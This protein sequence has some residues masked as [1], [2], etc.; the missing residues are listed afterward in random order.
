MTEPSLLNSRAGRVTLIMSVFYVAYGVAL[1]FLSRWLEDARGLDGAQIGAVLSLAQ[2]ARIFTGPAIAFWADSVRDRRTPIRVLALG[3]V[4]AFAAFFYAA[5]DFPWL[6][7]LGF[8]ALT[9]SQAMIPFIEAVTLRACEN[10]R[11]SYGVARGIGSLAFVIANVLGGL[12]IAR[13]GA[14]AIAVWV[15]AAYASVAAAA[16]TRLPADPAPPSLHEG[17][18]L[19][20]RWESAKLLLR[21]RR[22]MIAIISCGILQ[23][24]HAFYYGFSTL[25]WRNEGI[26]SE[27]AGMLWGFAVAVE[28]ALL[29][30]LPF[31][32]RRFSPEAFVMIGGVGAIVRWII[33]GFAPSGILLWLIQGMHALSFAAVHVGAMRLIYREA[34]ESAAGLAQTLYAALASGL[35]MGIA[36][37]ASG[38]L[39]DAYGVQG[40]W[41]MAGLAAFGCVIALPLFFPL[42]KPKPPSLNG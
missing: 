8:L 5:P 2:L 22:Y 42:S 14:G 21:T 10:G 16:W 7:A 31:L 18:L 9:L 24:A 13:F 39:Y 23:A 35:L 28:V 12:V 37:L 4:I 1:P 33:A 34:P 17:G 32:E 36:M 20:A 11:L 3:A 25:V 40:Y 27:L 41:A 19:A 26:D 29:W 38:A 30:S 6:L 15:I